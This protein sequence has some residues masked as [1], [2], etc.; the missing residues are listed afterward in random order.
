MTENN[1]LS[2]LFQSQQ[3]IGMNIVKSRE[4]LLNP[5]YYVNALIAKLKDVGNKLWV[6]LVDLVL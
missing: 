6:W 3:D 1:S 5:L 4:I 2:L